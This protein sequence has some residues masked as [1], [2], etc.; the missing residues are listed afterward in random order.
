MPVAIY[1]WPIDT[2]L[3]QEISNHRHESVHLTATSDRRSSAS[4]AN[5]ALSPLLLRLSL[6]ARPELGDGASKLQI[7]FRVHGLTL[8]P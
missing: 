6:P 8:A 7:E 1:D 2:R 3:F 5:A 4:I